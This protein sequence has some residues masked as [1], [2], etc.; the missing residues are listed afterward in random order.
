[1]KKLCG[2]KSVSVVK[3]VVKIVKFIFAN[4]GYCRNTH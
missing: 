3:H 4:L 2:N 1:V